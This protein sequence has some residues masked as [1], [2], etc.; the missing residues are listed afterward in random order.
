VKWKPRRP[1]FIFSTRLKT[2]LVDDQTAG[3]VLSVPFIGL[4]LDNLSTPITLA[5]LVSIAT[6]IG[7]LG[8]I[9]YE[10]AAYLNIILFVL[11][12]P[13]YYTAVSD[14]AAKVF[15]FHT[16]GKVYGLIICISGL[17]NFSQSALDA[18]THKVYNDDPTPAN[19]VLLLV[20]LVIGF[21]LVAYVYRK[22][23]MMD[24]NHLEEEAEHAEDA[25]MPEVGTEDEYRRR[26]QSNGTSL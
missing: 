16:F 26:G 18:L 17:F 19:L 14:Y 20:A 1:R 3:G 21:G 10:P 6:T 5:L 8:I 24:R 11:Y 9:P 4:I 15:G 22:S 7:V 2:I 25:F 23:I 12:R 13:L